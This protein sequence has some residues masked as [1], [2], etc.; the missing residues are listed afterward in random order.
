MISIFSSKSKPYPQVYWL[1]VL[2]GGLCGGISSSFGVQL[3]DDSLNGFVERVDNPVLFFIGC[4]LF[5]VICFAFVRAF[6]KLSFL[7]LSSSTKS[8]K[9]LFIFL[10]YLSC[11]IFSKGIVEVAYSIFSSPW[12][13]LLGVI[14]V[15]TAVL[16][17]YALKKDNASNTGCPASN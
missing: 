7:Y 12:L 2:F 6:I 8:R 1:S 16:I 14:D 17:F 5:F 15:L 10:Y 9:F 4:V 3:L 13:F 11:T